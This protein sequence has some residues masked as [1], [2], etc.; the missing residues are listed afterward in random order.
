MKSIRV[1]VGGKIRRVPIPK[2]AITAFRG[3][4]KGLKLT[5]SLLNDRREETARDIAEARLTSFHRNN[6]LATDALLAWNRMRRAKR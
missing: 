6:A 4:F 5:E 2:D 1:N 3:L